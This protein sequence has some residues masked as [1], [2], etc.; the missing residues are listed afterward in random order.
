MGSITFLPL[1]DLSVTTSYAYMHNKTKQD[2]EFSISGIP[3]I[4]PSVPYKD[5]ANNY[6]INLNY[7][8][9]D[10]INLNA[11]VN[12]T[13]SAGRFYPSDPNLLQ[14]ASIASFSELK[15]KE[16]VYSASGEYKFKTSLTSGIQYTYNIFNDV[17][18]NSYDDVEDGKAHVILLTLS[19]KW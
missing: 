6:A 15:T 9:D 16:T 1:D 5:T 19:K 17:L 8:P 13:N 3:Q 12:H 4:D 2:L 7:L 10:K 11:G 18:D 14:P